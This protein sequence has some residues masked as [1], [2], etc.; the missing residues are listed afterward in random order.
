MD[1]KQVLI[2]ISITT[3]MFTL[4]TLLSGSDGFH[5]ILERERDR[6][7]AKEPPTS[8]KTRQQQKQQ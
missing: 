5:F 7:P 2:I 3:H 4:C 8:P 1:S 6:T